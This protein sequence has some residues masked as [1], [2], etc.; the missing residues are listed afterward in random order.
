MTVCGLELAPNVFTYYRW[1]WLSRYVFMMSGEEVLADRANLSAGAPGHL[2][3]NNLQARRGSRLDPL[4]L[5]W[6][7]P[8]DNS[9]I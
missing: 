8:D 4:G 1:G 9:C 5:G 7:E 2:P 3:T 6:A